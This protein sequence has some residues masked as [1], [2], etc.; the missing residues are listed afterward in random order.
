MP[1][2]FEADYS[3]RRLNF[4]PL[5]N[6][7]FGEL[8]SGFL[9]LPKGHGFVE[10]PVFEAGY[11]ALKKATSGFATMEPAVITAAVYAKPIV[12][13]VLR[14]ILG[15]TPSEWADVTTERTGIVVDQGS[16]RTMDRRI[17][18][19][20]IT[21]L[22]DKGSMTDQRLK[23]MIAAAVQM[24]KGGIGPIDRAVI[25]HRLDK[26]DTIGGVASIRPIADLGVPY[27]MLLYERFLGPSVRWSP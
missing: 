5:I 10:Y 23:A 20:P 22:K 14:T 21:L 13:I 11:Q 18:V 1:L 25:L 9:E 6:E 7:V 8:K 2:R 12:L 16:A 15:F 17:R 19:A 26:V 3:D 27:P 24:L 4:D